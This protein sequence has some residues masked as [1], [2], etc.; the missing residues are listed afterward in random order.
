MIS[1]E[2]YIASL[3]TFIRQIREQKK[4]SQQNLADTCN[5]PKSTIGRI[6]RAEINTTI[7]TLVR[8]ANALELEPYKLLQFTIKDNK[9]I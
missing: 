7:R 4:I 9:S 5:L 2:E 8:I 6:E 3:G 1:E